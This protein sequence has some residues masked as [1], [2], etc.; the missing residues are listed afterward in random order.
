MM[1][2]KSGLPTQ[3][4]HPNAALRSLAQMGMNPVHQEH[5]AKA[6]QVHMPKVGVK[7]PHPAAGPGSPWLALLNQ[8]K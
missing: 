4:P 7:M 8:G 2:S 3:N 5:L 1:N 6:F